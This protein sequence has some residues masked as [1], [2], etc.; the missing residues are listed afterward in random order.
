[1]VTTLIVAAGAV[2]ALAR[3]EVTAWTKRRGHAPSTGTAIVN[4]AGALALGALIGA[5]ASGTLA[6]D[7]GR[8]LGA[9]FLGGFTTFSTW[10]VES[11]DLR[12]QALIAN[13]AGMVVAG[14]AAAAIGY[15]LA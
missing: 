11:V 4:L 8:V 12:G 5:T 7:A 15:R 10:M 2:G 13:T 1:M 9:G 3:A 6:T 14:V